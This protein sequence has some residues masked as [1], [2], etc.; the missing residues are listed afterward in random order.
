MLENK[1]F[2]YKGKEDSLKNREHSQNEKE[3]LKKIQKEDLKKIQKEDLKKI[4]DAFSKVLDG[5]SLSFLLG[6]GCS[7]FQIVD[8][9]VAGENKLKE[10]G[11]PTMVPLAKDFYE[12]ELTKEKK[13]WLKKELK[14]DISD[15][16]YIRNI[17]ML[18]GVLHSIYYFYENTQ[19]EDIELEK[20]IKEIIE[21]TRNFLLKKCLDQESKNDS[22]L[23]DLYKTF[24]RKLLYRNS[25][26]P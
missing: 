3:D 25:N 9:N 16:K 8:E 6:A 7:S 14:L 18:L 4:Q 10:V 1:L 22:E 20:T 5:K 11:I 19:Q 26:L 23:I 13:D 17:E 12:K 21:L 15:Q 24:Y 2:F